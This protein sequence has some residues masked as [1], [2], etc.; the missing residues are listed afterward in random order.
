MSLGTDTNLKKVIDLV[1]QKGVLTASYLRK[2]GISYQSML[3]YRKSGWLESLGVG[4]FCG[5][6]AK[7]SLDIA[8]VALAE[9]LGL[10]LHLGG[11]SA[12]ARRGVM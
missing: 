10:P 9:Q 6:C 11:R 7:P 3:E 8:L 12:L 5:R 1:R 4:A 2:E